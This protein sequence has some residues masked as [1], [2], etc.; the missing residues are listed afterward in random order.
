MDRIAGFYRFLWPFLAAEDSQVGWLDEHT[1][2]RP[3]RA[4]LA[5]VPARY[6]IGPGMTL[7]DLGCG[8][9]REACALG[10]QLGCRV[11][12][13]LDTGQVRRVMWPLW[14]TDDLPCWSACH[15]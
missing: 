6:G 10:K 5:E 9:G 8:K 12:G 7:L 14:S 13:V 2:G 3:N 15:W 11:I 1:G 4:F